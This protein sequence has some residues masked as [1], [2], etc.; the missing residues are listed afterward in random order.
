MAVTGRLG[1]LRFRCAESIV[2][3]RLGVDKSNERVHIRFLFRFF[4]IES[5]VRRTVVNQMAFKFSFILAS[6]HVFQPK[7]FVGVRVELKTNK[8]PLNAQRAFKHRFPKAQNLKIYSATLRNFHPPVPSTKCFINLLCSI[9][10][11]VC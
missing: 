4:V 8:Q 11:A 5:Q 6:T 7:L 3:A 2:R 9:Q 10:Q 1:T